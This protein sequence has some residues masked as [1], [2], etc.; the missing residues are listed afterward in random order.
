MAIEHNLP[1]YQLREKLAFQYTTALE[2][3]DFEMLAT[4]LQRATT[5]PELAEMLREIDAVYEQE[6]AQ[7][8]Q[9]ASRP[10]IEQRQSLPRPTFQPNG[11]HHPRPRAI[12]TGRR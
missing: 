6:A 1:L 8:M 11:H 10:V 3:G 9:T 2:N 7:A 12:Q 5:D 4:V